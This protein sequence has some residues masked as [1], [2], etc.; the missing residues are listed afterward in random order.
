MWPLA[1]IAHHHNSVRLASAAWIAVAVFVAVVYVQGLF[2]PWI[3]EQAAHGGESA[4]TP[5]L[6]FA[7][8]LLI[9]LWHW[10]FLVAQLLAMFTAWA[11][12]RVV[13]RRNELLRSRAARSLAIVAV[14]SSSIG[15]LVLGVWNLPLIIGVAAGGMCG[16]QTFE[17]T[18]SPNGRYAAAVIEIDCGAMS[19]SHRQVR[20][21][22][23]VFGWSTASISLLYFNGQLPLHLS[24]SGRTLA[25]R[26]DR[27][28]SSL[29]NPPPDPMIWGGALARYSAPHK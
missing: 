27:L 13:V 10:E 19:S 18:V 28:T 1:G 14:S 17:Q 12:W 9:I 20:L 7:V 15:A 6:W 2:Y 22:R 4:V 3:F 26:G 23:Q 5:A 16:T 11:T 24:W 29:D 21:T 8:D 25:I